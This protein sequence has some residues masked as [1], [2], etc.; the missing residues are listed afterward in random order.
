VGLPLVNNP[1]EERLSVY[2]L[3]SDY[4][5][6]AAEVDL[7][8]P[9]HRSWIKRGY[10]SGRILFSGRL[11]PA[12]GGAIVLRAASRDEVSDL[13]ETDPYVQHNL[14]RYAIHEVAE[15]PFPHRSQAFDD[16]VNSPY[17]ETVTAADV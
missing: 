14:V 10:E 1:G 5:K 9:N 6:P 17:D 3:I 11:V 4:L 2:I 12:T 13:I 7:Q 16:F 8:L 15:T